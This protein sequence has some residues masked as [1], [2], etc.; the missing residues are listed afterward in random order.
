MRSS[1]SVSDNLK[2]LWLMSPAVAA[3][4]RE[5]RISIYK[6]DSDPKRLYVSNA[7]SL[8]SVRASTFL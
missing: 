6:N 1:E 8:L 3:A 4:F 5:G 7:S 2:N